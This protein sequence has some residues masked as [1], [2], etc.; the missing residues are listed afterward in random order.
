VKIT[1][2]KLEKIIKEELENMSPRAHTP[3]DEARR[4]A[5]GAALGVARSLDPSGAAIPGDSFRA[6]KLDVWQ[7]VFK[8]AKDYVAQNTP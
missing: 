3:R 8:L 7:A 4:I 5:D 2:E 1:K 6:F